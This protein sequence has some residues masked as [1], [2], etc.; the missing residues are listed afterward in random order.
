MLNKE[1]LKQIG[2]SEAPASFGME[3]MS[4]GIL[5]LKKEKI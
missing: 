1:T 2:F 5:E 4:K 3:T